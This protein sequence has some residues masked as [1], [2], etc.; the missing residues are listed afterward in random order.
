MKL[1]FIVLLLA[2]LG[3]FTVEFFGGSKAAMQQ[4]TATAVKQYGNL[5]TLA[6]RDRKSKIKLADQKSSEI[7]NSSG[8]QCQLI[9]PFAELLHAEYLVERLTALD[10]QSSVRH[11]EISDGNNY[12]VYLKPEMSEK[13]ALR[14]LYEVQA[15]SID[16]YIIPEGELANGI[17]LGQFSDPDSAKEKADRVREQGY[18]PE[19]KQIPKNHSEIWVEIRQGEQKVSAEQ[20]QDLLKDE[21]A[22]E[23]RENYCFGVANP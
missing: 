18:A 14:R 10:V 21:K 23:R 1:I 2:N 15:K 5:Q 16:S 7:A 4:P 3:F 12:W 19:I 13:E 6:E 17:S 22:I 8:Q 9:G 11:I 20:W